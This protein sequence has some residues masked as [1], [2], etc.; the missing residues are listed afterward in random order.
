MFVHAARRRAGDVTGAAACLILA[1][2][3]GLVLEAWG[4]SAEH[5]AVTVE[6][7]VEADLRGIDSHGIG[8]LPQYDDNRQAGKLNFRPDICVVADWPTLAL[9]DANRA[10]GH[11]PARTA[12]E[13][14][15]V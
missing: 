12:M 11:V 9:I 2:E 14:A 13:L 1:L 4:M 7:M 3:F 8:M 6:C 5:A 10:L 15:I